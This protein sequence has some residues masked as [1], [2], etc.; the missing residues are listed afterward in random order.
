MRI[1]RLLPLLLVLLSTHAQAAHQ[2]RSRGSCVNVQTAAVVAQ[3][4][5]LD[6]RASPTGHGIFINA[7]LIDTAGTTYSSRLTTAAALDTS[8]SSVTPLFVWGHNPAGLET[9]VRLGYTTIA[10]PTQGAFFTVGTNTN[11]DTLPSIFVPPGSYFTLQRTS[12]NTLSSAT[13]CFT[14]V[15]GN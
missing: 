8:L 7:I 15:R 5:G 3:F 12:A 10:P 1:L 4:G 13:V 14:E 2:I 11:Y 9:A 6:L